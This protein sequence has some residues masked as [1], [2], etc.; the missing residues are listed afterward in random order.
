MILEE[1]K[2]YNNSQLAEWFQVKPATFT[3]S[4]QKKLEYLKNFAEFEEIK[5][6]VKI[7]KVLEPNYINPRDKESNNKAY[8]HDIVEV[9]QE[10]PLQMFKTCAGRITLLKNSQTKKLGHSFRTMYKYTRENLRIVAEDNEKIWCRRYYNNEF[11]FKPLAKDELRY[12]KEIINKYL[13][14]DEGKAE[15]IAQ[16]KSQEENG[17][18]TAEEVKNN[19]YQ[20][21]SL[22]WT[23]AKEE[24]YE[25]YNFVPDLVSRWELKAWI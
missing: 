14:T 1:G 8:Q 18:L 11:D 12:W 3:K 10:E 24:F 23:Q 16:W 15:L 7:T 2:V 20:I 21:N 17:E 25:V 4:K 9:I 13:A 19:L 5:C 6:K 22:C